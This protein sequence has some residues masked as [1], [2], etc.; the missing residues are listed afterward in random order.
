MSKCNYPECETKEALPF[1]CNYCQKLF[2]TKH[3]LPKN[4]NC[5]NLH[6]VKERAFRRQKQ[7]IIPET[8]VISKRDKRNV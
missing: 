8:K 6:L 2:C 1:K 4:H 5:E 3:R 7:E